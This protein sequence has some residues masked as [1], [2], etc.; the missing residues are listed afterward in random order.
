MAQKIDY[1]VGKLGAFVRLI[2]SLIKN[3]P[4]LTDDFELL[5]A[6]IYQA[7]PELKDKSKCANCEASMK[8]Y[9]YTF[10]AWDALLI[11]KM[12]EVIRHNINKGQGFTEANKV[13]VPDLPTSH[14]VKCRT[15]QSAKLGLIAAYR[16]DKKRVQ[17][18]WVITD[19]GWEALRGKPVPKMVRVWR[20]KIEER[21]TETIT[22]GEALKSHVD[23]VNAKYRKG[24]SVKEDHREYIKEYKATDWFQFGIHE[25]KIFSDVEKSDEIGHVVKPYADH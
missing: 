24:K 22:L 8:E 9:I 10:D 16:K 15:T 6:H 17:G 19:R 25:G 11:L 12:A 18:T 5:R 4:E 20:K 2:Q 1:H 21:Y 23:F 14:A 7:M 3:N 13:R